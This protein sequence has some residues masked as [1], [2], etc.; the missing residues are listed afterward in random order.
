MLSLGVV[1]CPLAGAQTQPDP[2][3]AA[4][5]KTPTISDNSFLVE[6]AYNQEFGVVQHIQSFTRFS[7]SGDWGYTFTQEWPV[8]LAPKNQ[9]SYTLQGLHSGNLPGSGGGFGDVLLN[10]RYQVAQT[11]RWAFAP[12]VSAILPTGDPHHARGAGGAGVQFNLPLSVR[13][14]GRWVT[15][16]NLG[17]TLIPNAKDPAGNKAATHGYNFGQSIIWQPR[18]RFNVV[19]ETLVYGNESVLAPG[20]SLRSLTVLMSPGVRWAYNLRNGTQIVPGIA[21]PVGIGPSR[22][23]AGVHFYFSVEHPYRKLKPEKE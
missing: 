1:V 18:A 19:L 22:G 4:P 20:Q 23:E 10:Y 14:S 2:P 3:A 6:E 11:E 13:L 16:W 5:E 9:L 12:R 21:V 8:D 15:H 17:A 7:D